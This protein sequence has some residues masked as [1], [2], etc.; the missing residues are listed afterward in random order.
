MEPSAVPR[1]ETPDLLARRAFRR[2][3]VC[4]EDGIRVGAA[5]RWKF[6][7]KYAGNRIPSRRLQRMIERQPHAIAHEIS[8]DVTHRGPH[9]TASNQDATGTSDNVDVQVGI[10]EE[11]C[12]AFHL[13]PA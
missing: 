4:L 13:R 10:G 5:H 7:R 12:T 3:L 9:H 11:P 2:R 8:L 1:W 6:V